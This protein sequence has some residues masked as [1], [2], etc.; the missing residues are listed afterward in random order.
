VDKSIVIPLVVTAA[1]FLAWL[2]YNH[3]AEFKRLH[4]WLLASAV[5]AQLC[6]IVWNFGVMYASSAILP[7]VPSGKRNAFELAH[8]SVSVPN[9]VILLG[10]PAFAIYLHVLRSWTTKLKQ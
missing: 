9:L 3:P 6:F 10:A 4:P 8:A 7:L 2:A 1:S 5:I